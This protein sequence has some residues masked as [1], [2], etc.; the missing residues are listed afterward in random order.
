[1]AN[2]GMEIGRCLVGFF[3]GPKLLSKAVTDGFNVISRYNT[4]DIYIYIGN[5]GL[6]Q[7]EIKK[8]KMF[9]NFR[10]FQK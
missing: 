2:D 10:I 6:G 4:I 5:K 3:S 8:F 9:Q 1:M 7:I